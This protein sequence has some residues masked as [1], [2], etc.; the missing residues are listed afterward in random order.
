MDNDT[1]LLFLLYLFTYHSI[2]NHND[3][4]SIINV[5]QKYLFPQHFKFTTTSIFSNSLSKLLFRKY[6]A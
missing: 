3:E 4:C 5:I 2:K 1:C 6:R